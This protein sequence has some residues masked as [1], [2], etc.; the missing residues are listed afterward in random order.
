MKFIPI[1][2]STAMVQALQ[3]GTKTQTRR[4]VKKKYDNTDIDWKIDKY[5]K[6]LVERQND[7]PEPVKNEDGTTT[8][9]MRAF[10][11]IKRPYGAPGDIL[12]VRE[13]FKPDWDE[14]GTEQI[15]FYKSD[16]PDNIDC[17]AGRWKPSIFMPRAACRLFLKIKSIRVERLQE[18]SEEDAVAEG[19][20]DIYQLDDNHDPVYEN[21]LYNG[22]TIHWDIL[23]DNAIHSYQTLWQSINGPESWEANPW[24]WV[25]EFERV[26]KP[27]NF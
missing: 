1:L 6:R 20:K 17:W 13:T 2:F 15:Y 25:V 12:W 9:H 18:I 7:V 8:H 19:I 4:V 24:V 23:A 27:D 14:D 3:A 16:F 22:K 10:S 11:E 26:D 5:G 21:Y